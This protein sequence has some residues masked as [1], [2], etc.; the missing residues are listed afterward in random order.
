MWEPLRFRCNLY[1]DLASTNP[2]CVLLVSY[3]NLAKSHVTC[4]FLK[5]KDKSYLVD[6]IAMHGGP[7][8]ALPNSSS[9]GFHSHNVKIQHSDR[10]SCNSP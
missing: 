6:R 7:G 9:R 3:L 8:C 10:H 1:S 2:T 4:F 5:N